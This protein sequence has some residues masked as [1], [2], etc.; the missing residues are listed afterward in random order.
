MKIGVFSRGIL[1]W[2]LGDFLGIIFWIKFLGKCLF[3]SQC[4]KQLPD[5]GG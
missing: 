5:G 2:F 3:L 4:L 1:G